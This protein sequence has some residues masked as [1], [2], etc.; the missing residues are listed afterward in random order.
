MSQKKKRQKRQREFELGYVREYQLH[1]GLAKEQ[2]IS[3]GILLCVSR[4]CQS[5]ETFESLLS[6]IYVFSK[7]YTFVSNP[8]R[9]NIIRF[10]RFTA[11]SVFEHSALIA[12]ALECC[13]RLLVFSKTLKGRA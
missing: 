8:S 1:F 10:F 12:A 2:N 4:C 9:K 3:E 6:A 7:P 5:T 11:V 13:E